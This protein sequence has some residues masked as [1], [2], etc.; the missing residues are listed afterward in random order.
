[1]KPDLQ[2]LYP[3]T[4]K[5]HFQF[6]Y[7]DKKAF[8]LRTHPQ[9]QFYA[10]YGS[11]ETPLTNWQDANQLA[12]RK[13]YDQKAGDI[14]I[15]L[16]GGVDSEICV[17]SFYDQKLPFKTVSLR[18]EGGVNQSELVHVER[19]KSEIAIK[20]EY[21]DLDLESYWSSDKFYEIVESIQCVSP[22]L[23]SHLWLADKVGG[24]PVIAQG[25]ALLRKK[26]PIDYVPGVSPYTASEWLL[27]ES[28]MFCTL[29]S[30]FIV[31]QKPGIPGFFQFLPEQ[32]N[33]FLFHNPYLTK[34]INNQ[35]PGKLSTRSSKNLMS[36]QF[37][38]D[39]K[40]REKLTGFESI[41]DL[42]ILK[43][44]ELANRFP[45]NDTYVQFTLEEMRKM[46]H[47]IG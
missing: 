47:K 30:Y 25:E 3:Y 15:L 45:D 5:N 22:I 4:Y 35:I 21:V 36:Y 23:A 16:S 40:P 29:Y 12:A 28:E 7:K 33:A 37:Y 38:P 44:K 9:D 6:G 17:R 27:E 26:I 18:Y 31:N 1:M 2:N 20:H 14:T 10:V 13:I 11:I 32:T 34:L 41:M 42:Q 24:T 43:R 39:L 46:L 8:E 19:L